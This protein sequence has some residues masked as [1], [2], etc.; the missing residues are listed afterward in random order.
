[1][2]LGSNQGDSRQIILQAME[3]LQ[4]F[5]V[6]PLLRSSLWRTSPVDCPPNSPAFINAVAGLTP[7]ASETPES[8]LAKLHELERQFGRHRKNVVNAPRP[9]DLDLIA[10]C[11]QT[12]NTRNMRLP[13]PRAHQR[14]FVLAPL[15]EIAP[16]LVL[17]FQ[18]KTIRQLLAGN[19]R[20]ADKASRI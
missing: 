16:G 11:A 8:L 12:R 19:K 1:M 7:P 3:R 17:P 5:S 13:H 15:C 20:V 6:Q 18:T 10:F 9:L 2:A 4:A 14:R